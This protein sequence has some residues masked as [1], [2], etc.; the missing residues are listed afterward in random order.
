[1]NAPSRFRPHERLRDPADYQRAYKLRRSASDQR[2]IVYAVENGRAYARL[3]ISVG[4]KRVR[5]A[6][7]RNRLKRL[8][9]EAFRL[10][11]SALPAG[12]DLVVVPR[13]DRLTLAEALR[14][15]PALAQEATRRLGRPRAPRHE[16]SLT[17]PGLAEP[18]RGRHFDRPDPCVSAHAQPLDRPGLPLRAKL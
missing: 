15:L 8:I 2:L 14:S 7:A 10:S 3:G 13:G 4:R 5:Q 9:R 17:M 16:R 12:V 11:K 1:M 18:D 6:T